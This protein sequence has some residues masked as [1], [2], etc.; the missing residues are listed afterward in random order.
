MSCLFTARKIWT[1]YERNYD[2]A[3]E[4][5]QTIPVC[6]SNEPKFKWLTGWIFEQTIQYCIRKELQV[7]RIKRPISEQVSLSGSARADLQVGDILIEIKYSG[8]FS[9]E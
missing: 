4:K 9:K 2:L 8:I 7:A 6:C 3:I 5:L 1:L